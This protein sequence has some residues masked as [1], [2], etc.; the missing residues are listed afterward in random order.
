MQAL[1]EQIRTTNEAR[2]V[3]H[4]ALAE[5]VETRM[6]GLEQ[7]IKSLLPAGSSP[8]APV[9]PPRAEA[10]RTDGTLLDDPM[11]LSAATVPAGGINGE[12]DSI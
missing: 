2:Q 7:L 6:N 3:S 9:T 12:D 10:V 4:A 5:Q 1:A 8:A 11:S